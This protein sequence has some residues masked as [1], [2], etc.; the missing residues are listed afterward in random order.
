[1]TTGDLFRP[2][3]L[4]QIIPERIKE[5]REAKGYTR[6]IFAEMLGITTQAV[7]QYEVGQHA[8]GHEIMSKII[9]V[10]E[11]PPAFFSAER[12]RIQERVGAPFWRSLARMNRSDRL[13]IARRLD[14]AADVVAYI[15]RFI[16]FPP[17]KLP[18]VSNGQTDTEALERTAELVRENWGLGM[19]PIRHLAPT[20]EA[21]GIILIKEPV[22]CEDM[23]AV[24]RWQSGRPY[25]LLSEDKH[26]LPREN[27]DLAHELLHLIAHAHIE[28]SSDNLA[29][30]ERQAN[31]FA[32]AFL[33]PRKAFPQEVLS[34]SI[35]Y[36]L[37]LKGRWRVS[38]QAMIYRCKDLGILSKN[39]VS[40]LWRQLNNRNM[41]IVEPLDDVFEPERPS[42]L[43]AALEMLI[44]NGVQSRAQIVD[45]LKLNA[46]DIESIS[47]ASPGFLDSKVVPLQ[48]RPKS[49]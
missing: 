42:V 36:F 23:D 47:G 11:Q 18:S 33:L 44:K 29:A 8:P 22:R 14:W 31:Y 32:G 46:A 35:D 43:F 38:V 25:V 40:Y 30:I 27:F 2:R 7:G 16:E 13:R 19:S 9:N 26:S 1:M 34:T 49:N 15:E 20:L 12:Q 21:N 28:V 48:L 17:P 6:E 4:P 24:S 45:A 37:E 39:Q 10:T 3:D 5:A 41:R